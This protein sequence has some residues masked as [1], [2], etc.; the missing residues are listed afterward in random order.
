MLNPC[1]RGG[2]CHYSHA[3]CGGLVDAGCDVTMATVGLED[4]ELNGIE[5]S[6]ALVPALQQ[7]KPRH[8]GEKVLHRMGAEKWYRVL[9][10]RIGRIAV[11]ERVGV[12]HQQWPLVRGMMPHFWKGIRQ[13]TGSK[14]PIVY[15]AHNLYPHETNPSEAAA[16]DEMHRA[17]DHLIV[18]TELLKQELLGKG[19]GGSDKVSVVPHGG[20]GFL[21]EAF[22]AATQAE[23]RRQLGI[24]TE[25]VVFLFFGFVRHYKGLDVLIEAMS[26]LLRKKPDADVKLVIAG[27]IWPSW[28]DSEELKLIRSAGLENH[29][30]IHA[31]YIALRD[32]G[33]FF[34][35]STVLVCPYRAASQSGV[36][37]LAAAYH[38]ACIVSDVGG[39]PDAVGGGR[40]GWIVRAEDVEKLCDCLLRVVRA[41]ENASAMSKG[42]NDFYEQELSWKLLAKKHLE[43]YEKAR[44]RLLAPLT[45]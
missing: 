25:T 16:S 4:F 38:R 36:V 11:R 28:G 9:G 27:S 23:A 42:A 22:P 31:D 7:V 33:K 15:T 2:I 14:L 41:P 34:S 17:A 32:V 5:T 3:L 6:Y 21:A 37:P 44:S 18:H 45:R 29:V 43:I 24:N 26:K 12:I 10:R 20:Y 19:F 35:A 1:D 8:L 13:A 40:F 30:M 39:L